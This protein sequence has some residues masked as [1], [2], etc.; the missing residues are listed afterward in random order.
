MSWSKMKVLQVSLLMVVL[1]VGLSQDVEAQGVGQGDCGPRR[2]LLACLPAA[3]ADVQPNAACCTVL[4]GY[5]TTSTPEAC[6]CQA[7]MSSAFASSGADVQYAIRIPQKCNL[8][9]RSG[10]ECNGL[11]I[12][13]GQ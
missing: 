7:A 2:A 4:Q 11:T 12:P 10:T 8:S 9:F 3:E 5:L 13:G 6:L 1:L